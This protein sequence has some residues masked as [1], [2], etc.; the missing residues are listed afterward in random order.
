M[1]PSLFNP[2]GIGLNDSEGDKLEL[3]WLFEIDIW[4]V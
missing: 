2:D 3:V 4:L 1:D